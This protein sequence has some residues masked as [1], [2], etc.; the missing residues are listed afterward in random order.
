MARFMLAGSWMS[1]SST[2]VTSTPQS[3]VW[4]PEDLAD[5]DVEAV[6]FGQCLVESVLADH[7]A[8]RGLRD[9]IDGRLHVLDRHDGLDGVEDAEVGDR[10]TS[11]LTLSRVMIP[12]TGS[13]W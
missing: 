4:R 7:L 3:A 5:A 9:L 2:R 6:R 12:G 13:A 8:E 10:G 1:F 11:T